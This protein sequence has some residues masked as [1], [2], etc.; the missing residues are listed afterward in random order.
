M[1]FTLEVFSLF[2]IPP[3]KFLIKS[4]KSSGEKGWFNVN[5]NTTILRHNYGYYIIF[6]TLY[7]MY[8]S[9]FYTLEL[10]DIFF[11]FWICN[12]K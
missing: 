12:K 11:L 7:Y 6:L 1:T 9:K 3:R 10:E 5:E 4:P 2:V 8:A